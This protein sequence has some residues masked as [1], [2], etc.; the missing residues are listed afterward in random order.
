MMKKALLSVSWLLT[1]VLAI[2]C[3]LRYDLLG[4]IDG[5]TLFVSVLLLSLMFVTYHH[6]RTEEDKN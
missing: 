6:T 3:Y 2:I 5:L 4:R 1:F